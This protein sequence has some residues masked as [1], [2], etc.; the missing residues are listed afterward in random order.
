MLAR[1]TLPGGLPSETPWGLARR[2]GPD[3]RSVSGRESLQSSETWD[4][5]FRS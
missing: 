4:V 3:P 1:A 5:E 2:E